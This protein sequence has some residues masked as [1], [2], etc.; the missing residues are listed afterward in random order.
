MALSHCIVTLTFDTQRS[1][2]SLYCKNNI[3]SLLHRNPR[4]TINVF[5]LTLIKLLFHTYIMSTDIVT[6]Q[7]IRVIP[8][9]NKLHPLRQNLLLIDIYFSRMDI[10]IIRI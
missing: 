2:V 6:L 9:D 8:E 10:K 4:V 3:L 7:V 5:N 1:I